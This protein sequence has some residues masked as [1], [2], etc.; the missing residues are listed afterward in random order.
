MKNKKIYIT[1]L[2]IVIIIFCIIFISNKKS[3]K[4]NTETLINTNYN[5]ETGNYYIINSLTNEVITE[6]N[7]E[8]QIQKYID[9]PDYNPNPIN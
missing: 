3:K 9:N 7:D 8:G 4:E 5:T 2:V 1:I 6:V